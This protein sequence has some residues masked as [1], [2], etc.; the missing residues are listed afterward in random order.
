ML[1]FGRVTEVRGCMNKHGNVQH[2]VFGDK[3]SYGFT[4][5]AHDELGE[6]LGLM[7]FETAAKLSGARFVVLK[8]G[9]ARLE[10]A[11]G[12]FMLDLHTNEH[13]YTEVNPP[14]VVRDEIM[15]GTGQL[16]KFSD[17]Q[18]R[19]E[20]EEDQ[21]K[22]AYANFELDRKAILDLAEREG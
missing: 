20:T 8:K 1:R 17:D 9:L 19:V 15:F 12:Q 21:R 3:R 10:R 7:D 5:K 18:Y 16:P 14:L 2:H 11:I 13:G 22:G 4:P 6:A